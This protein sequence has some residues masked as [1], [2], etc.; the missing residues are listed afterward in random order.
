MGQNNQSNLLLIGKKH[1]YLI[2][3]NRSTVD[4]TFPYLLPYIVNEFGRNGIVKRLHSFLIM[5]IPQYHQNKIYSRLNVG[6]CKPSSQINI[7]M[8]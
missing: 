2:K 6:Y 1:Q 5:N 8:S 3:P 7:A 4:L